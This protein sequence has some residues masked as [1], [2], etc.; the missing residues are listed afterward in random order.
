MS[1]FVR[2]HPNEEDVGVPPVAVFC[3]WS[4]VRMSYDL[5]IHVGNF[6]TMEAAHAAARDIIE[7][8]EEEYD[9]EAIRAQ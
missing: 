2:T 9:A 3:E 6:S 5:S 7:Y 8:L 4:A 1:R